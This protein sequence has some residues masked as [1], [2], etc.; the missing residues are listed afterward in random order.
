MTITN[1]GQIM[2]TAESFFRSKEMKAMMK[3]FKSDGFGG[4][5]KPPKGGC[6]SRSLQIDLNSSPIS[7]SAQIIIDKD[8][9]NEQQILIWLMLDT[10]EGI[11]QC[12]ESDT[13]FFLNSKNEL[14]IETIET[15]LYKAL[16]KTQLNL[17][18]FQRFTQKFNGKQIDKF[19]SHALTIV[20]QAL[21][22][23]SQSQS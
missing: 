1:K 19:V 16:G 10:H 18:K 9:N 13:N 21:V 2:E 17:E 4:T 15:G 20:D 23:N 6:Q 3:N 12:V 7:T 22:F 5:K 8:P 14:T 11:D